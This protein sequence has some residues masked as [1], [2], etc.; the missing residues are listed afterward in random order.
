MCKKIFIIICLFA[1]FL[2]GAPISLSANES[3]NK[4]GEVYI[5]PLWTHLHSITTS[6]DIVNGRAI[7]SGV[8]SRQTH[9][10]KNSTDMVR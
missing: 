2:I 8:V 7:L 9:E 4:H 6:L 1:V 3:I 10:C 5:S